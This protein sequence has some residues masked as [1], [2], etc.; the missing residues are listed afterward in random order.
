MDH[1]EAMLEERVRKLEEMSW[2]TL[3]ISKE[4]WEKNRA[5][6]RVMGVV[7]ITAALIS[8]AVLGLMVYLEL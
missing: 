7:G 3:R 1:K 4:H 2:N 5:A 6:H 8:A